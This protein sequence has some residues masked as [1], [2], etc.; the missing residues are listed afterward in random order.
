MM[1][2]WL[3]SRSKKRTQSMTV[4]SSNMF[5]FESLEQRYC[6][7]G[8]SDVLPI[9]ISALATPTD[10]EPTNR[11]AFVIQLSNNAEIICPVP[12]TRASFADEIDLCID[13]FVGAR[14]APAFAF[15]DGAFANALSFNGLL[16]ASTEKVHTNSGVVARAGDDVWSVQDTLRPNVTAIEQLR[17]GEGEGPST[18]TITPSSNGSDASPPSQAEVTMPVRAREP[19]STNRGSSEVAAIDWNVGGEMDTPNAE[20]A[21]WSRLDAQETAGDPARGLTILS[22][23]AT[24]SPVPSPRFSWTGLQPYRVPS[25]AEKSPES[26]VRPQLSALPD[27]HLNAEVTEIEREP[28][29]A[30][31]A[32]AGRLI[33]YSSRGET[34]QHLPAH[35]IPELP[36]VY[37]GTLATAMTEQNSAAPV[38]EYVPGDEEEEQPAQS[39]RSSPPTK[40][41]Y[42]AA[43]TVLSALPFRRR[44]CG[45][46]KQHRLAHS[47][48]ARNNT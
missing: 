46:Q 2:H 38:L 9:S 35:A 1:H 6:M 25:V 33:S 5:R 28:V 19:H 45:A 10:F 37:L 40:L 42:L 16:H 32:I 7:A 23:V 15:G 11:P 24:A 4:K 41:W 39:P 22:V 26:S 3:S 8:D 30:E 18:V 20:S 36:G 43:M 47:P 21:N 14:A 48:M 13:N 31:N 17:V 44:L 27:F 12:A 34:L 29:P